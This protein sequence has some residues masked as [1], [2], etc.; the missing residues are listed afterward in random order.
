MYTDERRAKAEFEG[1]HPAEW[2]PYWALPQMRLLTYQ[3]PGERVAIASA[4]D[5]NEF[6]LN[7]FFDGSGGQGLQGTVQAQERRSEMA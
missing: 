7:E 6:D 2:N 3:M 5:F 4:G 1:K